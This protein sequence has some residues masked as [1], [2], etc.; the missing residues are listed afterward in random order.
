MSD[1]ERNIDAVRRLEDVYNRRD[2]SELGQLVHDDLVAHTPGS[3]QIPQNNEGL[4]ANNENSYSAFPD[5]KTEILDAFGEG[6]R[7]V[8]RIRQTGTN[9]GGLP[10]FGVP[11]NDAKVDF[12]WVQISRHDDDGRIAETWAQ[13]EIPKLMM[14]LGAMPAPGGM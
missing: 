2:Y 6:D 5:R 10:W 12:E 8:A 7:T 1:V 13:I 3:D 4:I 9:T 14:Q 11:A